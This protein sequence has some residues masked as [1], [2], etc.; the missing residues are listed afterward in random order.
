MKVEHISLTKI[1]SG[2]A[3]GLSTPKKLP[4]IAAS[5]DSL[6]TAIHNPDAPLKGHLDGV[7]LDL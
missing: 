2:P 7:D 1:F 3:V 6:P 4:S 5:V